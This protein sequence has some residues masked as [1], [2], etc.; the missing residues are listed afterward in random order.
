M[1]KPPNLHCCDGP[2]W[3]RD[4]H[5]WKDVPEV[6]LPAADVT[7]IKAD[8]TPI[9]S[10]VTEIKWGGKR[11]GAGRKSTGLAVSNVARQRA[12]RERNA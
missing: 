6:T 9:K 7:A 8:V 1:K 10:D 3:A 11:E 2:H 5:I 4:P 12:Y